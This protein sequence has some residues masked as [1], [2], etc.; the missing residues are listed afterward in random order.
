MHATSLPDRLWALVSEQVFTVPSAAGLFNPYADR[1][2]GIDHPD[3]PAIRRENL[4]QYFASYRTAPRVLLLAEAPGP[5]GCRFSGVPLVSESQLADPAF[6][7]DG[8]PTSLEE[9]PH[10]EYSANIYWRILRPYFPAF[11]TWNTVPFH[12]Y[13][14]ERMLS[15]RNP[16]HRE[17]M[18]FRDVVDGMVEILKPE[19]I[20]AIGRKAE[21]V[22]QQLG[23]PCRYV[24][25]PSQGG[26]LLFE[27]GVREAFAEL[28]L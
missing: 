26:A 24:R 3:A 18:A 10:T 28:G 15:I 19:R 17:V 1:V 21:H 6:P 7:I 12:P 16:T 13:K 9:K 14:A 20:L 22:L 5:W 27:Q 4:R 25:H 8:T 11:F 23:L 2:D